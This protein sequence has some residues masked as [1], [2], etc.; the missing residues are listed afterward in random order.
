M[1]LK[2]ENISK[3]YQDADRQLTIL[4]QLNA[5]FSTSKS[6]AI[7]GASGIGK[8][9]LLHIL[10][11]LDRP[12][13]GKVVWDDTDLCNLND[14]QLTEF[15]GSNIGFIFQFHHLM[16]EFT[17][18]EN[19]SM[20]LVIAGE[21]LGAANKKAAVILGEMGLSSRLN[22]RPGELSGGEQQ[23]V[24][25][26]R[27]LIRNPKVI[28]ADEPTGNLD[29]NTASVVSNILVNLSKE[30]GI[31][32][33]IVTHNREFADRLDCVLEMQLGGKLLNKSLK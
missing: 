26:A 30:L 24:A 1:Q 33:I 18:L 25:I 27:A 17:A 14:D 7:I 16:P 4:D 19:A 15:R 3:T 28:L 11:G 21:E 22:H 23:R 31:T 6:Y 8:S 32:L 13:S 9:S 20:P 10:G 29:I 5:D 12:N 2:L